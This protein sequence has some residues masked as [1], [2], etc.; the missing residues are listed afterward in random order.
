MYTT[1]GRCPGPACT[2][3]AWGS[4]EKE[5]WD[6]TDIGDRRVSACADGAGS[7]RRHRGCGEEPSADVHLHQAEEKRS[8]HSDLGPASAVAGLTNAG[9]TCVANAATGEDEN[10]DQGQPGDQGDQ[11]ATRATRAATRATR[12]AT[13]ATRAATRAT[14]A[15]TRATRAATRAT[16]AA[17]RAT[18]AATRATRAATRATRAATRA[19]RAATRARTKPGTTGPRRPSSGSPPMPST[20]RRSPARSTARRRARLIGETPREPVSRSTCR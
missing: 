13:R 5:R 18:R 8:R 16:R 19:T 7:D 10:G 2:C 20:H 11:G 1:S 17:T 9:F 6:E 3:P 15:A 14:R 12:A 4:G